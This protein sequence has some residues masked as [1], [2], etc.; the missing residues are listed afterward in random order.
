M[1]DLTLSPDVTVAWAM[2]LAT[3]DDVAAE[4]ADRI[5]EKLSGTFPAL[6]MTE[7]STA[8]SDV[9][10][11]ARALVQIDC[12]HITRTGAADLAR[13]VCAALRAAANWA[14][15]EVVLGRAETVRRHAAH[16]TTI[17]DPPQPR[18]IVTGYLFA[19]PIT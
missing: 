13:T 9:D 3:I 14:D 16:D 19:K 10:G 4:V 8:D 1:T 2:Y 6:R 11:W 15:G 17:S 7:I 5:G 12:Y 18:W